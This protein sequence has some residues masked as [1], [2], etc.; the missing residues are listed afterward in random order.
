[1]DS[2][3]TRSSYSEKFLE[4]DDATSSS[5]PGPDEL[6]QAGGVRLEPVAEALVGEV[7]ERQQPTLRDDVADLPPDVR[8]RVDARRVVA[9]G[10]EQHH[11]ARRGA[12]ERGEHARRIQSRRSPGRGTGRTR[13]CRP[14]AANTWGWLGQVGVLSQTVAPGR[15][16]C[17]RSA[18]TRRAPVPPGVCSVS[19]RPSATAAL[20]APKTRSRT[21][22]QVRRVTRDR[23]VQL[24]R[25]GGQD[26]RL[27]LGDRGQHGR[28]AGLVH[29][30]ARRRG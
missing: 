28:D 4:N 13:S 9:A 23:L 21:G 29:E 3:P 17:T 15:S 20:P 5:A 27:G 8:G 30:H 1:M 19:T 6:Q 2:A 11:V 16:R 10:V 14:A 25:L 18:A 26:A 22:P 12:P 24:G 7:D